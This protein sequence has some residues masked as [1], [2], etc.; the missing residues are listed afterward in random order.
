VVRVGD[1]GDANPGVRLV[2]DVDRDQKRRQRLDDACGLKRAGVDRSQPG[3]NSTNRAP[4]PCPPCDRHR[5]TRPG[6][7]MLE[8]AEDRSADRVQPRYDRHPSGTISCAC[9][10]AEPC[11]TRAYGSP[12]RSRLRQVA[13]CS[14][15]AAAGDQRSPQ[16]VEVLGLGA[17]WNVRNTT[18]APRT[19]S[20][21]TSP[22]ASASGT[23][24]DSRCAA[25][26]ARSALRD[27]ITTA[28]PAAAQRRASR[29]RRRRFRHDRDRRRQIARLGHRRAML[30]GRM[31][32]PMSA[33]LM[34]E[35]GSG[36]SAN[37]PC[38]MRLEARKALVTGAPG[39]RDR[40]CPPS[41]RR[42]RRGLGG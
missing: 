8:V 6:R 14:R 19:A 39:H 32:R 5:A 27:P 38:A 9:W 29:S 37:H 22:C 33:R 3:I 31:L 21:L 23:A 7:V 2:A 34:K 11:Q 26:V 36:P 10:A 12:C 16:V 35:I 25:S 41:R 40:D 15:P 4:P 20:S 42:G 1:A 30:E 24:F 13:S 28:T 18:G 17:E